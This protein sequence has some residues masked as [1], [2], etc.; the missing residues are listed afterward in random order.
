MCNMWKPLEHRSS[1]EVP[2]RRPR[3]H[4][5]PEWNHH[6]EI[7]H[8]VHLFHE[9]C[10]LPA[11]PDPEVERQW[12]Q[13]ALHAEFSHEG[14]ND[15]VEG[16]ECEVFCAF[17]VHHG[18]FGT[19]PGD[20]IG[21]I[22]G[23]MERVGCIW[24]HQISEDETEDEC[25]WCQP[26]ML[27]G[28]FVILLPAGLA[29][30]SLALRVKGQLYVQP[31]GGV[32]TTALE[33][34]SWARGLIAAVANAGPPVAPRGSPPSLEVRLGRAMERYRSCLDQICWKETFL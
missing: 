3:H 18:A 19:S 29:F 5:K 28:V 34:G 20:R 31:Q 21:Q 1:V 6:A 8:G 24:F 2:N 30:S 9:S 13:D 23:G 26:C 11:T 15:G 12:T 16:D 4:V 27:S 33:D 7:H 32:L 17:S 22:D 10:H 14:E 25:Q